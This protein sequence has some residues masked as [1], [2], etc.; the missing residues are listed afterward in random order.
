MLAVATAASRRRHS[1]FLSAREPT[2]KSLKEIFVLENTA[3]SQQWPC[4]L[5]TTLLALFGSF[6]LQQLW[7]GLLRVPVPRLSLYLNALSSF[8]FVG[9]LC[10][11]WCHCYSGLSGMNKRCHLYQIHNTS[12][13]MVRCDRCGPPGIKMSVECAACFNHAAPSQRDLP[14]A[15]SGTRRCGPMKGL[16]MVMVVFVLSCRLRQP[17]PPRAAQHKKAV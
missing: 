10:A 15:A 12:P 11:R 3:G 4:L 17:R 8:C 1:S 5:N 14:A 9:S 6:S 13:L 7:R 2:L 16:S